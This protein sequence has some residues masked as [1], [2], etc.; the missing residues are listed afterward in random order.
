MKPHV[1]YMPT[2]PAT[3][4]VEEGGQCEARN[5][6][7]AWKTQLDSPFKTKLV[8]EG[9]RGSAGGK[10][11]W[12]R[13]WWQTPVIPVLGSWRQENEERRIRSSRPS[14]AT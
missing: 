9:W 14:S 2:D 1:V 10:T 6:G 13:V 3:R 11:A 4:E 8:N 7:V 5:L 12:S